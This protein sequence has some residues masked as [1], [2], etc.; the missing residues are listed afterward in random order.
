MKT[1][2]PAAGGATT[3]FSVPHWLKMPPPL[4]VTPLPPAVFPV[5]RLLPFMVTVPLLLSMPPPNAPQAVLPV[6]LLLSFMVT[7]PPL[8]KMPPPPPLA[9][10]PVTVLLP[11]MISVG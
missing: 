5:M 8:L 2:G 10:L 11:F 4:P 9:V 7:V 3:P 1:L 6:M